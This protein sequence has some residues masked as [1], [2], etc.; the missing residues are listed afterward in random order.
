MSIE[1]FLNILRDLSWS[2]YSGTFLVYAVYLSFLP[3]QTR[4]EQ[5]RSLMNTGV[6]LGLAFGL[7]IFNVLLTRWIEVGHYYPV[8]SGESV[9]FACAG[10][11]WVSNI[12]FEIWTLDPIRKIHQGVLL[13]KVDVHRSF[14][15][16]YRH[17]L[18]HSLLIISTHA[19][20]VLL[21]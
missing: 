8:S 16:C 12:A 19:S 13:D 15:R 17:L 4:N 2:I 1:Q 3:V 5:I 20:F 7:L 9:A 18:V 14:K 10:V 21:T 6:V 11:L